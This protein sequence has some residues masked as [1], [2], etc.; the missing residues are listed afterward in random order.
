MPSPITHTEF[1][2]RAIEKHGTTFDY[3]K[4][5]YKN[6]STNIKIICKIHKEFEQR[7]D[8]HLKSE[9]GCEKCSYSNRYIKTTMDKFIQK[10][11]KKFDNIF[12]YSKA[13]YVDYFTPIK[14]ICKIHKEFNQTPTD[15]LRSKH[16]CPKCGNVNGATK[17]LL[18][19]EEFIKKAKEIHGDEYNY[20]NAIYIKSNIP[21]KIICK[22]HN[23]FKQ[24]PN[25]HL[26]GAGC[27]KCHGNINLTTEEFIKR[28]NEIHDNK[29]DYS[30]T[31]YI[32]NKTKVTIICKD[33]GEFDQGPTHHLFREHGCPGC[34]GNRKM[35]TESFIARATELYGDKYDYSK[36]D[37][38]NARTDVII[39]CKK[40]KEFTQT[41]DAFLNRQTT[42][43]RCLDSQYSK[44]QIEWLNYVMETE[45][46]N[47]DHAE[48]GGEFV[49][50]IGKRKLKVDGFCK[51]TNTIYQFHGS[52]FHGDANI[53]PSDFLNTKLDKTMGELYNTTIKNE[54]YIKSL[55]YNL[56]IMWE[57]DWDK[58]CKIKNV[59]LATKLIKIVKDIY[60]L[61]NK[62][63]LKLLEQTNK[64][65]IFSLAEYIKGFKITLD[66]LTDDEIDQYIDKYK[67][68]DDKLKKNDIRKLYYNY[69]QKIIEKL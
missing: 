61:S 57:N 31:K 19:T 24:L 46:I 38:K 60:N 6:M 9:F 1:I 48:N 41:P 51:K 14:I 62:Y 49:I 63:I 53:Y 2:S 20:S 52:F 59:S 67:I 54:E 17:L 16:G 4:V 56:V 10:A 28:A 32:N 47:I 43:I 21:I 55:G 36:V 22:I 45:N 65:N 39:I 64:N 25:N 11:A 35:T 26:R 42:C 30:Q 3:S 68:I 44:K 23:E 29:Y 34:S 12:D 50:G 40:H 8:S 66:D 69:K 27:S 58:F 37:Y 5:K 13:K 33:H 15:H 7:P 18:T